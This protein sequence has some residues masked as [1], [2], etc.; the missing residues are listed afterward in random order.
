MLVL[1]PRLR[2]RLRM[3]VRLTFSIVGFF[4]AFDLD[5]V[6]G[7]GNLT[8]CFFLPPDL[9]RAA[10]LGVRPLEVVVERTL[11]SCTSC[12]AKNC[13]SSFVSRYRRLNEESVWWMLISVLV[14]PDS[15]DR[16]EE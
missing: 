3:T 6:G 11:M 4:L 14:R 2:S 5:V 16:S 7:G 13:V 15:A 12:Q 8:F 1:G 10:S 9:P